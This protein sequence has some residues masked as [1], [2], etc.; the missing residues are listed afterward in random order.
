[1][2]YA[3]NI[4]S[5]NPHK[6]NN[7][8][9]V[10]IAADGKI[11]EYTTSLRAQPHQLVIDL[12]HM[13]SSMRGKLWSL[14]D[15]LVQKIRLGSSYHDKSQVVFD[16]SAAEVLYKVVNQGEYLL[17]SFISSSSYES[18]NTSK[19][20]S[21]TSYQRKNN[22]WEK[23]R[24]IDNPEN[25]IELTENSKLIPAG[26]ITS[27]ELGKD[28]ENTEIYINADGI[29]SRYEALYLTNP[30]RLVVDVFDV[31]APMGDKTLKFTSPILKQVRLGTYHDKKV[32]I[33]FDLKPGAEILYEVSAEREKLIV[34]LL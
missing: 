23:V 28:G 7:A 32:R 26:I 34:S 20:L 14:K 25:I 3:K 21:F 29:L 5:I 10:R 1:M 31:K 30:S 6:E 8:L 27:L 33:V 2:H 15:P 19:L 11:R 18:S 12:P 9:K 17:V 16:L 24:E 22:T 4:I 13:R